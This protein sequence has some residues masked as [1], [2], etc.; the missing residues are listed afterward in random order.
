MQVYPLLEYH[1]Q[2]PCMELCEKLGGRSPS[3]KTFK[4][5]EY[6]YKEVQ[7]F[8]L[9]PHDLPNYIWLSATE[10]ENSIESHWPKGINA[11]EGIWRDFYTGEELTNFTKPWKSHNG[12][13]EEGDDANCIFYS[14]HYFPEESWIEGPCQAQNFGC[15]CSFE[16]FP[17]LFLRGFCTDSD[18][19]VI[20]TVKQFPGDLADVLL[21]GKANSQIRFQKNHKL[22]TLQSS[23]SN[24]TA[25]S[26]ASQI[27]FALGT[28]NWTI[29][30]DNPASACSSNGDTYIR[31]M[32]LTGGQFHAKKTRF[33]LTISKTSFL[34][35]NLLVRPHVVH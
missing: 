33:E 5:W 10:G 27:S 26:T 29:T 14:P 2:S 11:E 1:D 30:G 16:T 9:N 21:L 25:L 13:A 22:W 3:V 6:V 31:E 8:S 20:Y 7:H 17:V 19:E 32:K 24:I 12:D 35:P 18:L 4:D 15:M 23:M 34:G 28:Q